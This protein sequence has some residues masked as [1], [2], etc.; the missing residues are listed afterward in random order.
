MTS[1]QR[2]EYR[3]NLYKIKKEK[4]QESFEGKIK[5]K[6]MSPEQKRE[7]ERMIKE[8]N[9]EKERNEDESEFKLK[10]ATEKKNERELERKEDESG[11]KLKMANEKK[12]EREQKRNEDESGFKLKRATEKKNER[13]Q[14]RKE[15]EP[16][17]KLKRANEKKKERENQQM[18]SKSR[19]NTFR[20]AVKYGRIFECVC[21]HCVYHEDK[22]LPIHDEKKFRRELDEKYPG[23]FEKSIGKY[24][25][26]KSPDKDTGTLQICRNCNKT[27]KEGKVPSMANQNNLQL[28]DNS[29]YPELDLTEVENSLIARNLI[30]QKI[31]QLPKSRSA[32]MKDRT[33][34][35]PI[36][37][38]DVLHT[39]ETLP[40]TP[41]EAGIIPVKLKRKK[42]YKNSHKVEYVDVDKIHKALYAL[43]DSGNKYYQF[44][45]VDANY[46]EKCRS[47]D[48]EGFNFIFPNEAEDETESDED[49]NIAYE[50]GPILKDLDILEELKIKLNDIGTRIDEAT[51]EKCED[52]LKEYQKIFNEIDKVHTKI[53][54]NLN[55]IKVPEI[56]AE[57]LPPPFVKMDA[58]TGTYLVNPAYQ[59]LLDLDCLKIIPT[60]DEIINGN[61]DEEKED[62]F[63]QL[64]KNITVIDLAHFFM[65]RY[66]HNEEKEEKEAEQ[67]SSE[68]VI[69]E[70]KVAETLPP[71]FEKINAN[72]YV[73]NENDMADE[74]IDDLINDVNFLS[75]T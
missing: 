45:P 28:S 15:D 2:K 61:I 25:T 52:M 48:I 10:R 20:R 71:P 38:A 41:I 22:V 5:I 42:E 26:K 7:Y 70:A 27:I 58:S 40:R 35:I 51:D 31:Y 65:S 30:F 64:M 73:I 24:D 33:I 9:R 50:D 23:L 21:C 32:A 62:A 6:D 19:I 36:Y 8:K 46:K 72:T 63:Y 16:G 34:N 60:A 67:I 66:E 11:F 1:E 43:K 59:F 13:E 39:V 12:N 44:V 4:K 57:K 18:E 47:S 17:F 3:R 69:D 55:N 74:M 54:Q 56:Y 49:E 37:E 14:E 53:N 75:L 29:K 68:D